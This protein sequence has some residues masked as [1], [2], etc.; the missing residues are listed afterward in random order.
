MRFNSGFKGLNPSVIKGLLVKRQTRI[1]RANQNGN[2]TRKI[3]ALHEKT[4][5][6]MD[7]KHDL[8]SN[9]TN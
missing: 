1:L 7:R 5:E 6:G 9:L 2:I 4:E 8:L 3:F